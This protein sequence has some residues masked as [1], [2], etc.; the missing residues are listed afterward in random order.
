MNYDTKNDILRSFENSTHSIHSIHSTHSTHSTHPTHS[1]YPSQ[2]VHSSHPS[3]SSVSKTKL[4]PEDEM[5]IVRV[6][7]EHQDNSAES[8]SLLNDNNLQKNSFQVK[9]ISDKRDV[10]NSHPSDTVNRRQYDTIPQSENEQAANL[11][12]DNIGE[13]DTIK[14]NVAHINPK[15]NNLPNYGVA[16]QQH[17]NNANQHLHQ[18]RT[19]PHV[20]HNNHVSY[21]NNNY[22]PPYYGGGYYNNYYYQQQTPHYTEE[23]KDENEV[24]PDN[25]P[26][27]P[28]CLNG[29]TNYGNTCYFNSSMQALLSAEQIGFYF[30]DKVKY[31]KIIQ[32]LLRNA[33]RNLKSN[34]DFDVENKNS[35][36]SLEL[37][38]KLAAEDYSPSKLTD[39]EKSIVIKG[40]ITGQ[41]IRLFLIMRRRDKRRI[42]PSSIMQLFKLYFPG[43]EGHR[44]Q[45]AQ[46]AYSALV[47]K[48][49]EELSEKRKVKPRKVSGKINDPDGM[50]ADVMKQTHEFKISNINFLTKILAGIEVSSTRC[51]REECN[52]S[53]NNVNPFYHLTLSL[54][55]KVI[56]GSRQVQKHIPVANHFG[57][58]TYR[59]MTVTQHDYADVTIEEC[60]EK[61]CQKE[62]L[63]SDNL[64][65]CP[66]CGNKVAAIK[67]CQL[68]KGPRILMIQLKRF[69]FMADER[70]I[71][72]NRN[73]IYPR[74][75]LDISKM[76]P[77]SQRAHC[78]KYD[79]RAVVNHVGGLDSG[80]YNA[81]R[82]TPKTDKG[83]YKFNDETISELAEDSVVHNEAYMLFYMREDLCK[84]VPQPVEKP[85]TTTT[86]ISNVPAVNSTPAPAIVNAVGLAGTPSINTNAGVTRGFQVQPNPPHPKITVTQ[87]NINSIDYSTFNKL[88]PR[89]HP[90]SPF[91]D[92]AS[93]GL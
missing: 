74:K 21:Y 6:F 46:E 31:E 17:N 92:T 43:F 28:A 90:R 83:W 47:Q 29:F 49:Q 84:D 40:T 5:P 56:I 59:Y 89:Q 27:H 75:G 87:P 60:I 76:F 48:M 15:Y 14:T 33:K 85:A 1:T 35:V 93:C 37:R 63:D 32:C 13:I 8:S 16:N 68:W 39:E 79:L 80:H 52:Y 70:G 62:V 82:L 45:D 44:H 4:W 50:L 88:N 65:N 54:P 64:W 81:Y 34:K 20:H 26:D 53:S 7:D 51:P 23:T 61:Y 67:Q 24:D 42:I 77:E 9:E 38:E 2:P 58:V 71:K 73:V 69:D 66:K 91:I 18:Q 10:I 22:N 55:D 36:I 30:E 12:G 57:G 25:E 11:F 3:Y 78:R 72:D 41:I 19:Q 86:N